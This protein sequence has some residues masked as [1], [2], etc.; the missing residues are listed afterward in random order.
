M[1][2]RGANSLLTPIVTATYRQPAV[3]LRTATKVPTPPPAFALCLLSVASLVRRSGAA[4]GVSRRNLASVSMSSPSK[5]Q[6]T[7]GDSTKEVKGAVRDCLAEVNE[8]GEFKR[9]DAQWR[10]WITEEPDAEFPAEAGRYH[11]YS[12]NACPWAN[13]CHCIIKMKGLE[14]VI[15]VSVAHPTWQFS[16]KGVDTHAGW[17]FKDPKDPPVPNQLGFGAFDCEGCIPDFVNNCTFV[18][19]VYE[20]AKDTGKKY[21]VPVLWDKKKQTIVSNE[22]SEIV[23][24]LNKCFNKFAKN[25][26]LDLFPER[27]TK[28][29]DELNDF[30]YPNINNGVYKCG[31]AKTQEAYEEAYNQLFES[32]EKAEAILSKQ[33]YLCGDTFTGMDL[34]LYMTL[35]RFDPVYVV[36]FKCYGKRIEEYPNLW[37][38]VKEL[39][40]MP[41]VQAI[42][43]MKHIKTHYF[44]SHPTLNAC[45]VIPARKDADMTTRHD[46]DRFPGKMETAA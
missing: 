6:K 19:D 31:F 5:K 44:T 24:M 40:Q 42:T 30:I 27:L 41:S 17:I 25:P 8:R 32:L 20:L 28:E 45:A 38:F 35:V 11:L 4:K 43:N 29:M 39:Y 33:R 12:A 10:R 22:S 23:L 26:T 15:S 14:D 2:V 37:N 34:K 13:R 18:R 46:R 7:G 9:V 36:Y 1:R 16:K 3:S 21:S